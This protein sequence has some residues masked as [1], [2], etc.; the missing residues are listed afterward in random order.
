MS[1]EQKKSGN[2][3]ADISHDLFAVRMEKLNQ[4]RAAGE[5]PF[6]ANWN[7]THTSKD[8]VAVMQPAID[9]AKA[10]GT[11]I[12]EIPSTT[13]EVSVAGRVIA[14]RIMGKARFIF[15]TPKV[16]YI[17]TVVLEDITKSPAE[18]EPF[19]QRLFNSTNWNL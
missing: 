8:C 12:H 7:Q 10:A 15:H 13:E 17:R 9:A 5:D 16:C 1:D 6:R 3:L 18:A 2:S 14:I 19:V 4:L 11:D